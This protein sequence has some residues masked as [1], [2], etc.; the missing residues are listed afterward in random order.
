VDFLHSK[1]P[2]GKAER[3]VLKAKLVPNLKQRVL[4]KP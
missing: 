2:C 1:F 3:L 4:M